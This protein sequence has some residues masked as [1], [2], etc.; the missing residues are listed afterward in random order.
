MSNDRPSKN[1]PE[2]SENI[3]ITIF[4]K[5]PKNVETVTLW[6]YSDNKIKFYK[7]FLKF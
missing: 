5:Y 6:T 2:I 3:S 1:I 7:I 4:D